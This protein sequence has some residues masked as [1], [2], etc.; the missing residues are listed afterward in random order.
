MKDFM[1]IIL[2]AIVI[3][4]I[5]F[6]FKGIVDRDV[7]ISNKNREELNKLSIEYVSE[8]E[9]KPYELKFLY[10]KSTLKNFDYYL[11]YDV[12]T[13]IV[14]LK[15]DRGITNYYSENGKLCKYN[16]DKDIIEE[17]K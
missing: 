17:I 16:P 7:V 4:L 15:S 9:F 13:K 3:I 6:I 5:F 12:R 8:G 2:Y 10:L 1:K 14:Y 11:V